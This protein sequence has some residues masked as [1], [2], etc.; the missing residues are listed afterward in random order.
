[1][2]QNARGMSANRTGTAYYLSRD[3]A[4]GL[5]MWQVTR[6]CVLCVMLLCASRTIA[7]VRMELEGLK[8]AVA[9]I[10]GA[11]STPPPPP[12]L[13]SEKEAALH[14]PT[15]A[16]LIG[17][18]DA[19]VLAPSGGDAT[20]S[21]GIALEDVQVPRDPTMHLATMHLATMHP[22]TMRHTT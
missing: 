4:S 2:K 7:R 6:A 1:M 3:P 18:V 11:G 19:S 5:R 9:R 16:S 20:L 10:P 8:H 15:L 17:G 22:A 21:I 12:L 13:L 14:R